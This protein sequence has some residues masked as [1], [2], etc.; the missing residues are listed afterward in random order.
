VVAESCYTGATSESVRR[1]ADHCGLK[2]LEPARR[3]AP[4]R[5]YPGAVDAAD[6]V[7]LP[8]RRG[9]R[10]G[11]AWPEMVYTLRGA[12]P[13]MSALPSPSRTASSA[14]LPLG[15]LISCHIL[16]RCPRY[17]SDASPR[18]HAAMLYQ[19]MSFTAPAVVR[20][21][22]FLAHV[23]DWTGLPPAE[24]LGRTAPLPG[25]PLTKLCENGYSNRRLSKED[26]DITAQG[27]RAHHRPRCGIAVHGGYPVYWPREVLPRTV[28]SRRVVAVV[29]CGAR[30]ECVPVDMRP[31]WAE[32]YLPLHQGHRE[33]LP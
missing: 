23:G 31:G 6:N 21:G 15:S 20:T 10:R 18:F 19:H 3:H 13:S 9:H 25:R 8:G 16:R 7:L 29:R 1:G 30:D 12:P 2:R 24:L 14:L 28:R 17:L 26:H 33:D 4:T 22:D 5:R 32:S 27:H 11:R